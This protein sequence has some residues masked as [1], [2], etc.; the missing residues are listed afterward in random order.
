MSLFRDILL[1][2]F[3]VL[4]LLF[5]IF[6]KFILEIETSWIKRDFF[7]V[8]VVDS[9]EREDQEYVKFKDISFLLFWIT[10]FQYN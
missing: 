1:D 5:F 8:V 3:V 10:K 6:L 7:V 9:E 4:V 2:V